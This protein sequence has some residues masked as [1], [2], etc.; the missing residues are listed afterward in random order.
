[1]ED[2]TIKHVIKDYPECHNTTAKT[3]KP[4]QLKEK[5]NVRE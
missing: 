1:M 2:D 4:L 5:E 3:P